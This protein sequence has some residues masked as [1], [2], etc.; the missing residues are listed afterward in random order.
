MNRLWSR[1]MDDLHE[2]LSEIRLIKHQVALATQFRGYGPRSVAFSGLLALAVA[3]A[4]SA[5]PPGPSH[6]LVGNLVIWV[7]TAAISLA[8]SAIDTIR[9]SRRVHV[10]MAPAMLQ[11]A[12]EQFV[13][14]LVVGALLAAVF[15]GFF[16][17][18]GWLLPGLWEIVFSLGI[19]ASCR[20]LPRPMF[21][22]GIWYLGAG[23]GSLM[24][25]GEARSF[26]P[27][28]MGLPF[29]AGQLMVAKVLQVGLEKYPEGE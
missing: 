15:A 19:F 11:A 20:F 17:D 21:M 16:P 26:L 9:R 3:C 4:E 27:W 1:E 14:S 6:D 29:G 23:L 22:V 2:A 7:S 12:V 18:E 5:A 24:I 28:A 25:C 8:L 13:P 10:E